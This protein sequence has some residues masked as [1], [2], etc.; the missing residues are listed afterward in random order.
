MY[1]IKSLFG[2]Y[3][4]PRLDSQRAGPLS[5]TPFTK[6]LSD[7][8]FHINADHVG[9]HVGLFC[10]SFFELDSWVVGDL[11]GRFMVSLEKNTTFPSE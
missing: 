5:N 11:L 7:L 3:P 8:D 1:H 2:E 4:P 9:I 10:C 6:D